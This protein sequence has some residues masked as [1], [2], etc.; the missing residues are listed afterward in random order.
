[1]NVDDSP[2]DMRVYGWIILAVGVLGLF[3]TFMI[4]RVGHGQDRGQPRKPP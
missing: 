2:S 1:V 4:S 3:L